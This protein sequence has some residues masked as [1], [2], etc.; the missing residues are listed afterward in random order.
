MLGLTGGQV[1][2]YTL[3]I[4]MISFLSI[5]LFNSL[6]LLVQIFFQF[7]QRRGLYF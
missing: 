1:S 6:E 3:E 5:G 7:K 4:V 2:G